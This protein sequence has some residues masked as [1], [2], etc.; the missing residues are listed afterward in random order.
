MRNNFIADLHLG[1]KNIT[2]HRPVFLNTKHN[3]LFFIKLLYSTL[4]ENDCTYFLGDIIFDEKYLETIYN[5]PGKKVLILGNHCTERIH[6]TD[7][8]CVFDDIH[9]SLKLSELILTHVPTHSQ[10]LRGK[11]CV[12]G[13]LHH[14]HIAD[15]T[16]INVSVDSHFMKYNIRTLEEVRKELNSKNR[17]YTTTTLEE[18]SRYIKGDKLLSRIYEEALNESRE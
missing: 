18:A 16:Y 13:H 9:S 8:A 12:H 14:E 11:K 3:D 1:H 15:P 6:I 2:R 4:R 7:L 5:L 10:E 17:K